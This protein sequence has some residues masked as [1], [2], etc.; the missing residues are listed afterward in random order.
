MSELGPYRI[1]SAAGVNLSLTIRARGVHIGLTAFVY[2]G[3]MLRR[4]LRFLL[5]RLA[6]GLPVGGAEL[7]LKIEPRWQGAALAVPSGPVVTSEGQTIRVTR[8]AAVLSGMSLR[9]RDGG[10]VRLDGQFGA[11]EAE[12][13]RLA[14][15]LS[16]IPDG[17]YVGLELQIGV[18][19]EINHGDPGQWAAGH[20]LNPLV[21]HL[22]WSWQGGY[23]FLALEGRWAAGDGEERG[24]LYHL[25]TDAQLMTVR[26]AA[27]F[28]VQSASVV[29]LAV[30]LA[31]VFRGHRLVADD[32]S[33]STHSGKDDALASRLVE[34]TERAWF[35]IGAESAPTRAAGI[36]PEGAAG[37]VGVGTPLAFIV[38]AGFPQPTLPTDNSLTHEGVA[39]G[40]ALFHDARL[41]RDSAQTCASCHAPERA[42]SDREALSFGAK[43]E[44]GARN[45]MPLFNLA[46]AG[47]FAWDGSQPRIRDQALA[48]MRNP[49]EMAADDF[50]V[51]TALAKDEGMGNK[52]AAAFGDCEV[53]TDRIG[54]ALEQYLMTQIS[55][56]SRF[57]RA[58]RGEAP[59]SEVE[60]RGFQLFLTEYDPARGQ[61]G[62]DCFHCHGGALFTDFGFKNNGLAD[63]ADLGRASVTGQ[64]SDRG[65]FKTPSL[66]N[67]AVTAP[68]MH[69]GSVAT[70]EAVIAHYDHGVIRS[71]T[72]DANLAKHPSG[73]M[74]L[75]EADQRALVA[76]LRT[77]TDVRYEPGDS[78]VK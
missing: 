52:F 76:F 44:T 31:R 68:Y 10:T 33:E 38:P 72:L 23:V 78:G 63:A 1:T 58:M 7:T 51:V 39:L 36:P 53:T 4:A 20:P 74:K 73:G 48:A 56:D 70:L 28:R 13:G 8:L 3:A 26:F 6:I 9:R 24:F 25:G 46:W 71:A 67:V 34:A 49:R 12:S 65:R 18:P 75:S 17:D 19:P 69:D 32:A 27:D 55:A 62:A 45:A 42:F 37:R 50:A 54:R 77:L 30:D 2:L 41:S 21:N 43:G 61:F 14:V 16:G 29:T 59:L 47:T 11:I 40:A 22:H 5:I 57:D 15:P 66:R 60:Q 35:W 64:A